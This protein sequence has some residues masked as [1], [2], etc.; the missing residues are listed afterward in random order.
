LKLGRQ[1]P[2]ALPVS[3]LSPGFQTDGDEVGPLGKGAKRQRVGLRK[4]ISGLLWDRGGQREVG[5]EG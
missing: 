4:K 5:V 1:P 2:C 3:L